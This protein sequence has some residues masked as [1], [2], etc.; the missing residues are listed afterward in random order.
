MLFRHFSQLT[1]DEEEVKI[2]QWL[3]EHD[4]NREAYDQFRIF[5]KDI[6]AIQSVTPTGKSYDDQKAWQKISSNHV[7]IQPQKQRVFG[8]LKIA[9]SIALFVAI[10][11]LVLVNQSPEMVV[12][13]NNDHVTSL[14]L[15]DGSEITL[16]KGSVLT[17]PEKF[18]ANERRVVMKGEAYFE[19]QKDPNRPFIIETGSTTIQV[20]GTSFNVIEKD[21]TVTVFVDEGLVKM[22]SKNGHILL[23]AG[24]SGR[25]KTQDQTLIKQ[26]KVLIETH[27]FWRNKKL[28][29][30]GA[31]LE[32]VMNTLQ[33]TH[34]VSTQFEN[35]QLKNC[36]ITVAFENESIDRMLHILAT[37]L[38]ISISQVKNQIQIDG[39]TSC[40]N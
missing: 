37:T 3:Q 20:L 5:H 21:G 33:E 36:T 25:F 15:K 24:T 23:P 34:G 32:D 39:K 11:W 1:T 27:Q 31:R 13:S 17:H 14:E 40:N 22:S 12:H 38:N 8:Y 7:A 9:A 28:A 35:E 6:N 16:N 10:G 30:K 29:F 2:A 18:N 4:A 26:E 19:I